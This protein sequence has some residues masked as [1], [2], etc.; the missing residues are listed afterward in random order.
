MLFSG[1]LSITRVE[2]VVLVPVLVLVEELAELEAPGAPVVEELLD[3]QAASPAARR[4][5]A[6]MASA[7]FEI[8]LLV[9]SDCPLG[10]YL[11]AD[12]FL[13]W[14]CLLLLRVTLR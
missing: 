5:V 9:N 4:P 3:E 10:S 6:A 1:E 12:F 2:P 14:E 7:L 8:G 13:L 11:R